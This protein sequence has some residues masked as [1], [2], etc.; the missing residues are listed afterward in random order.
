MSD[1][2]MIDKL[3][4][5]RGTSVWEFGEVVEKTIAKFEEL[6]KHAGLPSQIETSF[7]KKYLIA[8]GD[9]AMHEDYITIYERPFQLEDWR[10][11]DKRVS[12]SL[13]FLIFKVYITRKI[14]FFLLLY[15]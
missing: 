8:R 4:E 11:V 10:D 12:M 13:S 1:L 5:S 9:E 3:S 6:I 14:Y 7:K 2:K 15:L